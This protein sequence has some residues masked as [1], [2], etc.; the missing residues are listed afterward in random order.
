MNESLPLVE[1]V[2][3]IISVRFMESA[4]TQS[5]DVTCV[6]DYT[7]F[8]DVVGIEILDWRH[9][10]S[11]GQIDA[12]HASGQLWWSYDDEIDALY[13]HTIGGR[14]QNQQRT[15]ATVKLDAN[16]RVVTVE[17]ALPSPVA[18]P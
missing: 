3:G 1:V 12:P 2:D 13:I 9:Q 16:Q 6:A 11:G 17:M 18:R 14:G 10:V 5:V 4:T 15:T 8:G 7:D